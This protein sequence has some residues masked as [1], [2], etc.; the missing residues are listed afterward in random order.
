MLFNNC[1]SRPH[2]E[3]SGA[4]AFYELN[5]HG[6]Q[7]NMATE[8]EP[9]QRCCFATP[10]EDEAVEFTWYCFCRERRMQ[11]PDPRP[12]ALAA[13]RRSRS[14]AVSGSVR[15]PHGDAVR[16]ALLLLPRQLRAQQWAEFRLGY[17]LEA[18]FRVERTVPR[19]VAEGR[20]RHPS[21]STG[22]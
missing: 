17:R 15:V 20:Q 1:R 14:S 2:A 7:A 9:A 10:A 6:L 3:L 8:L 18:L 13:R 22:C 19:Q 5:Q 4:G 16:H 12:D 11:D 21:Q